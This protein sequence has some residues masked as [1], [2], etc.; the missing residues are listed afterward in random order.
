MLEL[1]RLLNI[2]STTKPLQRHNG[3]VVEPRF[4]K[5]VVL[6]AQVPRLARLLPILALS[7]G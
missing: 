1:T 7:N 2:G 5:S 6:R 4:N 3:L